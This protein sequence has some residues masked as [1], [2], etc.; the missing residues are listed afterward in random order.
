[1][2][3][4]GNGV[5]TISAAAAATSGAAT[6]TVDQ[7]GVELAFVVQPA[8]EYVGVTIDPGV[9]VEI[10]D[11]N[12]H[13]VE[14]AD[15]VVT[16]A[17]GNNPG[18][19]TLS[20]TTTVVPVDGVATFDN[21]T[22]DEAG[23][24]YTLT[25]TSGTVPAATSASFDVQAVAFAIMS[26]GAAHA[27]TLTTVGDAF[28]WGDNSVGQL[29]DGSVVSSTGPVWVA[30]GLRFA[31]L[32]GGG[33]DHTCGLI[34]AG[35]AYCWGENAMGQLGDGTK[36]SSNVPVRSAGNLT[37]TS[38]DAGAFHTC[39]VTTAGEAHCWGSNAA[40]NL[41]GYALG[42]PTAEMCDNPDAPYRGDTWPCSPTP[43]AVSGGL[44]F[45]SITAGVWAT[46]GIAVSGETYCW[47][48]NQFNELGNGTD[49]DATAPTLV[50]G[51]LS[52]DDVDF[53]AVHACGL[54]GQDAY[55][56]GGAVPAYYGY[57]GTGTFDPSSTPAAVVGG[58]H[59]STLAP[60]GGNNIYSFTCGLTLEGAAYCWGASRAGAL[61]TS[62][63]LPNCGNALCSTVPVPVAGGITFVS[64]SAGEEFACGVG[65]SGE[66]Y[67]WGS[68]EF[69]QLGDGTTDDA[70][71]PVLVVL[72]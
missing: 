68:N 15:E 4:V 61:G 69:G 63:S 26:T 19:G 2:T 44:S 36:T 72:P 18:G 56:W 3:A 30:G 40:D 46:C 62:A 9:K 1:V 32:T 22:I 48:W 11:A 42:G 35:E 28:C 54:I 37:F 50:A 59:F 52:F 41:D 8:E 43:I 58:L 67:C 12:G 57:L 20:G 5:A 13:S 23:T 60:S 16:L 10:R 27:C 24:G 64:I 53:G 55:C 38:I 14:D 39:G 6:V 65:D 29:G 7:V 25:A 34:D 66:G 51:G 33:G 47:G 21:L 17:I 49:V 45:R 70:A 31:E 71:T